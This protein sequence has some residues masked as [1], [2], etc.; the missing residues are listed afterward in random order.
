MNIEKHLFLY[1]FSTNID[2]YPIALPVRRKTQHRSLLTLSQPL[3]Y[4]HFNLFGYERISRPS[5]EP[6]Y[7]TNTSHDKQETFLYEYA[8]GRIRS[9]EKLNYLIGNRTRDLP[10]CNVAPQ[11]TTLR[12]APIFRVDT[13]FF[14]LL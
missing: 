12:R 7:A 6:L 11:P 8:A 4:L 5:C 13:N 3:P 14:L 2:T 9:I 1:I 10:A